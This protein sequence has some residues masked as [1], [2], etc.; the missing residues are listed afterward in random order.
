MYI[1]RNILLSKIF[2]FLGLKGEKKEN[3]SNWLVSWIEKEVLQLS[4][5]KPDSN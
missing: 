5:Y 2:L 3:K 4:P 1:S